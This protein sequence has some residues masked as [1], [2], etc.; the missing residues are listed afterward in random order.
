MTGGERILVQLENCRMVF[1]RK[2][3]RNER[4]GEKCA[5]KKMWNEKTVIGGKTES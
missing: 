5:Y 3:F 1:K 4:T 2:L